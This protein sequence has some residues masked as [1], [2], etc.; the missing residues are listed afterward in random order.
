MPQSIRILLI[1]DTLEDADLVRH[2]LTETEEAFTVEHAE[3][4]SD[5]LEKLRAT[6]ADVVLLDLDLPDSEGLGTIMAIHA[7]FPL[8]PLVVLTSVSSRELAANVIQEGAQDCLPKANIDADSLNR[9]VR[10]AIERTHRQR[11]ESTLENSEA[12]YRGLVNSLPVCVLQKDMDGRFI[13][14]NQAYSD[15]TGHNVDDILGKT[16]FDL[17]PNDVA[18]KFRDDDHRV[19][20][21][22]KLFRTVEVNTTDGK[23]AWVEVI[24]SPIRDAHGNIVGTQAIFWDVTERQ[25]AVEALTRAKEAA[26]DASRAKS[27]FLANMSHEIRTPLN[28]VIGMA[29]LL[30]DTKLTSTQRDYLKMILE[31]GESLLS[32]INDILDFSKIEAG[33]L[34][35]IAKPFDIRETVGDMMK[36][37]GV[38]AGTNHLELTCHF[39]SAVPAVVEGDAHRLRQIVVNLVGN[40]I[41]FT[42]VGEIDFDVSVDSITPDNEAIL[43]FQ[44]RDTGIGIPEGKL[45]KIFEAFEQADSGSTRQYGGT[46]LGLAICARLVDLMDGHIWVESTLGQGSTFHFTGRFPIKESNLSARPEGT[47][48]VQGTRVLIV[49]DNAT[50]RIILDEIVRSWGMRPLLAADADEGLM[51]L[52]EAQ[53]AGDPFTLL[54]TDFEMPGKNGL[55][56]IQAIRDIPDLRNTLITVLSSSERPTTRSQCDALDVSGFLMKPVKQSELFDA[57]VVALGVEIPEHEAHDRHLEDHEKIRPLKILLA[58]D[59]LANQRLAIALLQ[60]WG[61]SVTLAVNGKEGVETWRNGAFDLVIMDVQMPEMDGLEATRRIRNLE[62]I[63]GGHIPIVAMTA[64]ALTGDREKCLEAGMDGY[65]SKPLRI[66][67]L[68]DTIAGFFGEKPPALAEAP[69]SIISEDGR[70]DWTHALQSCDGDTDLLK[71]LLQIFLD[72]TPLLLNRLDETIAIEDCD[73]TYRTA[74]TITGSLRILGPTPANEVVRKLEQAA[75]SGTLDEAPALLSELRQRLNVLSENAADIISGK[76]FLP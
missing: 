61:H 41:K 11:V 53:A 47:N 20:K 70:V 48:R 12:R 25:M 76:Q 33:K 8:L 67:E 74:H 63:R 24:K 50:N 16:D 68:Y 42:E 15:F 71:D 65:T 7:D 62:R 64:H 23:T 3:T 13:F 45:Q 27:E 6:S 10:Y 54:L 31:S 49:D 40:A 73:A 44:V 22:G 75:T 34:D 26:E 72:E 28:A 5:G 52:Q 30:L 35:L 2:Y 69:E 57:I 55:E 58:E 36:P 39:D 32:V 9:S 19:V 46:G 21:S 29:E 38:R 66:H 4:L 37:L 1:E 18:Q 56:L 17:S 60:K 59:N 51:L 14:A 43:H